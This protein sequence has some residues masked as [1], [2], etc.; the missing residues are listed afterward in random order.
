[1]L[2]F[3][4]PKA[5][6]DKPFTEVDCSKNPVEVFA[7]LRDFMKT[8]SPLNKWPAYFVESLLQ[9][10]MCINQEE[11][12]AFYRCSRD[13]DLSETPDTGSRKPT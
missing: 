13:Q 4:P 10:A 6:G 5:I 1:M 3:L 7:S 8:S 11:I 12:K 9:Q 2:G